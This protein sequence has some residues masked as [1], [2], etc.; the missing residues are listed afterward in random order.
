[1][2]RF[3]PYIVLLTLIAT[4]GGSLFGYD[5]AVFVGRSALKDQFDAFHSSAVLVKLVDEAMNP[6][7]QK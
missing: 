4:L 1:M 3:N 2:S 6:T 7:P 5:T